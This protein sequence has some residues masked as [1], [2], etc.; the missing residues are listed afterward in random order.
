L[1]GVKGGGC[2]LKYKTPFAGPLRYTS[3]AQILE[4][5]IYTQI[6]VCYKEQ[7]KRRIVSPPE[8]RFDAHSKR[9]ASRIIPKRNEGM[10]GKED[11][12]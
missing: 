10:L 3:P 5:N 6:Q 4:G 8:W 1:I 2:N 12:K 11:E 7:Y 9:N